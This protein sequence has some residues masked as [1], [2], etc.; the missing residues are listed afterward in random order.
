MGMVDRRASLPVMFHVG[1]A[2]VPVSAG[3]SG[4]GWVV[5][6]WRFWVVLG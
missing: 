4:G 1:S 2:V 6:R 5:R 3:W